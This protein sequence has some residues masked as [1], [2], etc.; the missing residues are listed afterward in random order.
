MTSSRHGSYALGYTHATMG[1]TKGSEGASRSESH[2][3]CPQFRLQAATR[4]HE[5]GAASNRISACCGEYV[6]GQIGK[7][8]LNSSHTVISYAVFCL[9]KKKK[10]KILKIFI[11]YLIRNN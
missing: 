1:S 2:Q 5:V 8:R 10:K 4:L 7:T 3:N 6:P 11:Y 9:K